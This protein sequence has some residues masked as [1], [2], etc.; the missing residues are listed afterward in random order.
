MLLKTINKNLHSLPS[1][2]SGPMTPLYANVKRGWVQLGGY[3]SSICR[4]NFE[5]I[6][7]LISH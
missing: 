5:G 1:L 3:S 6:Q 7:K 2:K 4:Q